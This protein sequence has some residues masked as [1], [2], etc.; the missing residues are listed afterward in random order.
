MHRGATRESGQGDD[1]TLYIAMEFL[2]GESL[3]EALSRGGALP[4]P[5]VAEVLQQ[6]GRG[7]DAAC[8]YAKDRTRAQR[9]R[10]L[11]RA[12]KR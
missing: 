11:R 9:R 7:V 2:E 12:L 10:G 3:R 8:S 6:A 5:E 1:G 4:L